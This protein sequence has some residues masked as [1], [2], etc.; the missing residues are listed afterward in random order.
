MSSSLSFRRI[1]LVWCVV[2]GLAVLQAAAQLWHLGVRGRALVLV[3]WACYGL[4][5]EPALTFSIQIEYGADESRLI[6]VAANRPLDS[7][8]EGSP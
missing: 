7:L 8:T 6:R 1:A 4:F 5:L 3:E 2:A